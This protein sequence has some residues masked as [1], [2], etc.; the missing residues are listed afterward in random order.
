[1]GGWGRK[2]DLRERSKLK[3][4]SGVFKE[5]AAISGPDFSYF[6]ESKTV[7]RSLCERKSI[8][9]HVVIYS[10]SPGR[11]CTNICNILIILI[12]DT[13]L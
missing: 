5:T 4:V 6:S 7:L 11:V 1:M 3:P 12:L 13:I 9:R 10:F 2:S 8:Q